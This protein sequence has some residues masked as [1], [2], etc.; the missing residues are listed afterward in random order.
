MQSNACWAHNK[1][2]LFFIFIFNLRGTIKWSLDKRD[3]KELLKTNSTRYYSKGES[4]GKVD[5]KTSLF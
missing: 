1:T 5:L 3:K 2:L 4:T